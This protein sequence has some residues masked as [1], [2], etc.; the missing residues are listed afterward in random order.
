VV[1]FETQFIRAKVTLHRWTICSTKNPDQL[2][3]WARAPSLELTEND[4]RNRVNN[5]AFGQ[6]QGGDVIIA[7]KPFTDHS[8]QQRYLLHD[9]APS[10]PIDGKTASTR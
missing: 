7:I 8:D 10:D 5:L 3:A 6:A 4:A 2:V 1:S 9:L